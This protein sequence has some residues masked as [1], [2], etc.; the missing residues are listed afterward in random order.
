MKI[1]S[2]YEILKVIA[3]IVICELAGVIGSLFTVSSVGTWYSTINKPSFNPP[4]W[5]FGPVWITLYAMMGISLYLVW[6]SGNRSWLVFGVFGLQLILNALW[7]ILFF[8]LHSPGLAFAEIILL[9]LSIIAS[10][11]L[12]FGTSRPA[13]YLLIPYVLWVSFAA[14]LNFAIW[15]L[16]I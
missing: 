1:N 8:G 12:F 13:A 9:W 3:A 2:I 16:N 11:V 15:R 6:R 4:S 7:S 14:V 5:V 10:I